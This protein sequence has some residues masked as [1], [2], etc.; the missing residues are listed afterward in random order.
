MTKAM[1]VQSTM[2]V[3]QPTLEEARN[4]DLIARSFEAWRAGIG[5]PFD[6]LAENARWTIVGNS[7]AART[8]SSREAFLSEVIRP[9]NARLSRP[10]SPTIRR[11][12]AE[13]DTVIAFFDAHGVALD[14]R[15]YANT[16]AWFL[17]M[18]DGWIV[19]AHAFFDSLEF[20]DF[21]RRIA[22]S[23]KECNSV[24]NVETVAAG[25]TA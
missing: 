6:L 15:A 9:F 2:S 4:H 17:R 11:L 12:Y 20:D 19:E 23:P 10:L 25:P 7:L 13:G 14:G 8:Y 18:Q 22:P 21:W 1:I 24:R 16:Y 5:G 3:A